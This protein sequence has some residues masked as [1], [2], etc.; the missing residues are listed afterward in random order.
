[1]KLKELGAIVANLNS[2]G[3]C[4]IRFLDTKA[5]EH[6]TDGPAYIANTG[7]KEWRVEGRYIKDTW[8]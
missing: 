5:R 6:R 3:L 2:K 7:Y 4:R 8:G 1:M